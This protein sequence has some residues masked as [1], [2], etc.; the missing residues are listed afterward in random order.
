MHGEH[1]YGGAC[2][3]A[4]PPTGELA[5]RRKNLSVTEKRDM[6]E[7]LKEPVFA[8]EPLPRTERDGYTTKTRND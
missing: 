5:Q 7:A 4:A 6:G 2:Y 8:L 1:E 3:S